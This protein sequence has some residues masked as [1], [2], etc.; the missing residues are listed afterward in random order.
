[1]DYSRLLSEIPNSSYVI[2]DWDNT[3]KIYD[4]SSRTIRSRF[5]KDELIS[6]KRRQCHLYIISAVAPRRLALESLLHELKKL[7]L[8]EVFV[9]ADSKIEVNCSYARKG[10]VV[11]CGY[12]K[13]ETFLKLKSDAE[14]H[15]TS[16][17]T[18]DGLGDQEDCVDGDSM[19]SQDLETDGPAAVGSDKTFCGDTKDFRKINTIFFDDEEVNIHNFREIVTDSI[20]H[21]VV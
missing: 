8:E 9:E 19:D 11:A 14:D 13:A 16:R 17:Y 5:A 3:L 2:F 6:L 4:P 18:A 12:D 20:C 15:F 10:N 1:M 21:L 7:G